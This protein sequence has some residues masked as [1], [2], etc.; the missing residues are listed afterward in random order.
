MMAAKEKA[1]AVINRMATL[2][3]LT[4]DG[5]DVFVGSRLTVLESDHAWNIQGPLVLLSISAAEDIL[6]APRKALTGQPNGN[7]KSAWGT[8]DF[9]QV[10]AIFSQRCVCVG[11]EH[12]VTAEF[13]L[14]TVNAEPA[15]ETGL[16]EVTA[17]GG[18]TALWKIVSDEPHPAIGGGLFCMLELPHRLRGEPWLSQV[19]Q[20]LNELEMQAE[21]LP[22]H[23]GAWCAGTLG[24]NPAYVSFLPNALHDAAP[25]I[26]ANMTAWALGRAEWANITLASFGVS[27]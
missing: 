17:G 2:G 14:D 9:E 3:A 25:G 1:P 26:A 4:F 27:R 23:F 6:R 11:E 15:L 7:G 13:A 21:P 5:D 8:R 16:V 19:L 12:G 20:Q 10:E 24:D 18:G 22:P